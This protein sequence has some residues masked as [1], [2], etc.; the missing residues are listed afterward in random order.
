MRCEAVDDDVM[1]LRWEREQ[2]L[3]GL[4]PDTPDEELA[5]G[6]MAALAIP[7][8]V[9]ICVLPGDP[10]ALAV[11]PQD[12]ATAIPQLITVPCG[13]QLP[14][15]AI[16]RGTSSGYVAVSYAGEDGLWRSFTAVR[17]HGG[18]DFFLGDQGGR[19]WDIPAAAFR[20]RV[21]YLQIAVCWAWAAFDLQREMVERFTVGGPFRAIVAVAHTAGASL[22]TFGAGWA[23]PGST[24]FWDQ[25]TAVDQHVLLLEDL[26]EWPDAAGVEGLALR[27]G[28]RLDLAFGGPGGR[29]LDRTG[30]DE[31]KFRPRW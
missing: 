30:P 18:V 22:G 3:L 10:D 24:G 12:P 28:A 11:P 31:G 7:P 25:P 20:R 17:W 2:A 5:V 26:A 6:G 4:A 9:R 1:R 14:P 27:F 16:V 21:V 19:E 23:E 13:R 15:H 29:H 8:T